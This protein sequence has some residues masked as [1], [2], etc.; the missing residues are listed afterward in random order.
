MKRGASKCKLFFA[1]LGPLV[2]RLEFCQVLFVMLLRYDDGQHNT[3]A[4]NCMPGVI[5]SEQYI[6]VQALRS[7]PED[8]V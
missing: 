2:L 8:F 4:G 1:L 5:A 7:I 6:P 3:L